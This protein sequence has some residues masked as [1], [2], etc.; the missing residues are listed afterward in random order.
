MRE[1]IIMLAVFALPAHAGEIE[2]VR[3]FFDDFVARTNAFDVGVVDLYSPEARIITLRDGEQTMEMAGAQWA[4]W[5]PQ[6]MPAAQ[7]RGDTS[8]FDNVEVAARNGGFRVTATRFPAIK[9]VPDTNYHLDVDRVDGQW[10]VVEE[11]TETVSLSQCEPS[12]KLAALLANTRAGILP[13]LPVDLDEET[14]LVGVEIRGPA[15]IYRQRL[16]KMAA[17][18][19]DLETFLPRLRQLSAQNACATP[20]IRALIDEGATVRY[21]FVDRDS[22]HLANV[23]VAPGLCP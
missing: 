8:T 1:L 3:S 4:E 17:A 15:I 22:T 21:A 6:V 9:C 18:E 10:R 20:A 23:D 13:H 12:E 2:E 16:Y 19:M 11:Y 14:K 5:L 7:L